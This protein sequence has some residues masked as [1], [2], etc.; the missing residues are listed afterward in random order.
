MNIN[1]YGSTGIIG[2]K[3]IKILSNYFPEIKINLLCANNN[4]KKLINQANTLFPKCVYIN[5]QN[6]TKILKDVRTNITDVEV[7]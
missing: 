4:V 3:T 7:F 2:S 5:N 6:K 1:I